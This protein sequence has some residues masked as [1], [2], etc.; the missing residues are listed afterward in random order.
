MPLY[1]SPLRS[2]C[3]LKLMLDGCLLTHPGTQA[4]VRPL[5]SGFAIDIRADNP[6]TGQE[7]WRRAQLLASVK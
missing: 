1:S 7:I 4:T 6:T 2:H 5:E 3:K